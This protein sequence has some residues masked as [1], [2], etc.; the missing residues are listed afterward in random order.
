MQS[1]DEKTKISYMGHMKFRD[2]FGALGRSRNFNKG[3]YKSVDCEVNRYARYNWKTRRKDNL[4]SYFL[5]GARKN[6]YIFKCKDL[7]FSRVLS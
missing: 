5:R 6:K 3:T 4:E 1:A 7:R 2:N